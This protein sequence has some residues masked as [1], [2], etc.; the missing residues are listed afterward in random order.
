M[1]TTS[2]TKRAKVAREIITKLQQLD[3]VNAQIYWH[4]AAEI[5]KLK[6]NNLWKFVYGDDGGNWHTF[7]MNELKTPYPS[8]DQK[9]A[10]YSFFVRKHGFTI[11]QLQ[12]YD[13]TALYYITMQKED[14]TKDEVK[15]WMQKSQNM[16]RKDFVAEIRGKD[17]GHEEVHIEQEKLQVCDKCDKVVM[18]LEKRNKK[19]K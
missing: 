9:A 5:Y 11:N 1:P 12:D 7:C 14:E 10:V 13:T 4:R 19:K 15:D 16:L 6:N 2:I 3:K 17:C 8:A 18:K